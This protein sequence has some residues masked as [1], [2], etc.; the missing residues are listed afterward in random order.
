MHGP[1]LVAPALIIRSSGSVGPTLLFI[2]VLIVVGL[3][4]IQ[5]QIRKQYATHSRLDPEDALMAA[6][7]AYGGG[8]SFR[9]AAGDLS[10]P[11]RDG[12]LSVSA[13]PDGMGGSEVHIWLSSYAFLQ[14]NGFQVLHYRHE[15]KKLMRAVA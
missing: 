7:R 14:T 4:I 13:E 15:V 6:A 5:V 8:Q 9:D 10:L 1:G 11:F 12:I 3:I 2:A